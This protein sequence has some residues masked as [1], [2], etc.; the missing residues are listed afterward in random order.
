MDQ[1]IPQEPSASEN[2]DNSSP[3]SKKTRRKRPWLI[4]QIRFLF[5]LI[6]LAI[7]FRWL[8]LEAYTIP[9]SSM[10]G[11][12]QPG[13]FI[14]VSKLH[15]GPR[16]PSTLLHIPLTHRKIWRTDINSYLDIPQIRL[17]NYRLSTWSVKHN[18]VVV[19]NYPLD[20]LPTEL[21]MPYVKRCA[22]LPGETV[23]IRQSKIY[24]NETLLPVKYPQQFRYFVRTKKGINSKFF[25]KVGI[26]D[27]VRHKKQE[28]YIYVLHA[29]P[30]QIKKLAPLQDVGLITGIIRQEN[31]ASQYDPA[32]FPSEESLGWNQ[33]F[34]GPVV[35]PKKG[36]KLPMS[37]HNVKLYGALV[38]NFEAKDKN[39]VIL[40]DGQ[41]LIDGKVQEQYTFKKNYYFM[42]GDNFHASLDSRYWG[43]VPEDHII[44][45]AVAVWMS[46]DQKKPWFGGK[47]RWSRI[48]GIK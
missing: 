19:F 40:R 14:L 10:A 46:L 26:S 15:Y 28:G 6:F 22:G 43:F 13:D 42:V 38:K 1:D 5:M 44:G 32:L 17:P 23:E 18:D 29:S 41:L 33:D 34:Y 4:R 39:K 2:L 16:T 47:I 11:T 30:Y 35:V 7:L 37:P 36:L 45:K 20:T 48:G 21:K 31:K 8:V 24:A 27:Y 9:S 3:K 25:T 12:L